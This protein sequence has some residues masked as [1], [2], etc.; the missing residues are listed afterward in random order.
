M[1]TMTTM[2]VPRAMLQVLVVAASLSSF[3]APA[4]AQ[5]A[6]V[7]RPPTQA[8]IV[9]QFED[10]VEFHFD[11]PYAG[12]KSPKQQADV[13]LPKRRVDDKP[14]PVVVFIHGGGWVGGDRKMQMLPAAKLAATG[15]YATVCVGYRLAGEQP[16]PTQIHD[17]KAAVRWVRSQA[18]SWNL[19]PNRIGAIGGSA[20]GMLAVLLGVT[21]NVPALEGTVGEFTSESSRVS[22]VVNYCGPSDLTQPLRGGALASQ[23]FEVV[24]ALLGGPLEEKLDVA[25]EASPVTYVS[26]ES[27]P[28]LSIHGRADVTVVYKHTEML[29]AALRR[30]GST[31]LVIPLIGAGHNIPRLPEIEQRVWQFWDRYLRDEQ[32]ELSTEPIDVT[33]AAAQ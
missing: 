15:R 8:E 30:A 32:I 26:A 31:S 18:R 16:W 19:D 11:Q 12:T 14:L 3:V 20:G 5:P 2:F 1:F 27:P 6:T 29:D 23:P 24:T 33:K 7:Q 25:K 9:A 22:C 10:A 28:I 4:A 21:G 13:Y 17:C